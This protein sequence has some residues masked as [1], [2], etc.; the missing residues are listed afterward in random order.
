MTAV[1]RRS[2]AKVSCMHAS[3]PA[4]SSTACVL[5]AAPL[6]YRITTQTSRWASRGVAGYFYRAECGD[7]AA[8]DGYR[9]VAGAC[10]RRQPC[11]ALPC[12]CLALPYGSWQ[13]CLSSL[14]VWRGVWAIATA[15]VCACPPGNLR[16]A[17]CSLRGDL[18]TQLCA[19]SARRKSCF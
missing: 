16:T 14:S 13:P 12:P 6:I 11:P 3:L 15:Q 18:S 8:H 1:C 4:P 17:A 9:V 2:C 5:V 7:G 10:L 19:H